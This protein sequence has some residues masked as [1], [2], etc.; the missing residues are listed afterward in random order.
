[1][2][3]CNESQL[4][5]LGTEWTKS[6]VLLFWL[7]WQQSMKTSIGWKGKVKYL[8]CIVGEFCS[9]HAK[10]YFWTWMG[11]YTLSWRPNK[12]L[13]LYWWK[14]QIRTEGKGNCRDQPYYFMTLFV[15]SMLIILLICLQLLLGL[16]FG[17]K[18]TAWD[19][20]WVRIDLFTISPSAVENGKWPMG[21][22]GPHWIAFLKTIS[23]GK[24]H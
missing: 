24:P 7:V 22:R 16:G 20:S 13:C 21:K 14:C 2:T 9:K 1:M 15:I 8:Y 10:Y 23:N 18:T 19:V 17:M 6:F 5:L 4:G 12:T 11:Q 3:S